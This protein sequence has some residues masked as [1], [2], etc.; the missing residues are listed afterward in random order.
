MPENKIKAVVKIYNAK[1]RKQ[2][3]FIPYIRKQSAHEINN[4]SE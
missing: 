4:D 1:I 2:N 3:T